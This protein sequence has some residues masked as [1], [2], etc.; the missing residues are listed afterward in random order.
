MAASSA[1]NRLEHGL[2]SQSARPLGEVLISM[3]ALTP[4]EL[5][6][7]L[8]LQSQLALVRKSREGCN[9]PA[10]ETGELLIQ[11]RCITREQ[12]D[13]A[14]LNCSS[15]A[16]CSQGSITET[17]LAEAMADSREEKIGEPLIR[18]GLVTQGDVDAALALQRKLLNAALIAGMSLSD[19]PVSQA[20]Q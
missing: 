14:L 19:S 6:A 1:T 15:S 12:L 3:G 16:V 13:L 2:K 7:T 20:K 11:A 9:R 18:K 10:A 5:K 8:A 17:Q 4:V